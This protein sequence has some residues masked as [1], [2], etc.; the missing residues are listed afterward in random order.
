MLNH[1]IEAER[2]WN[3]GI[4]V[5]IERLAKVVEEGL[6]MPRSDESQKARIVLF[7]LKRVRSPGRNV[8]KISGMQADK[9]IPREDFHLSIQAVE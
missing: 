5:S 1:S 9:P 7:Q 4:A 2:R 3:Q 6:E 8:Q